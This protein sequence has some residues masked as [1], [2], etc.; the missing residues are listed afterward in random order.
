MR[1]ESLVVTFPGMTVGSVPHLIRERDD[2]SRLIAGLTSGARDRDVVDR[3]RGFA[4]S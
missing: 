1:N 3:E 2:R 4:P